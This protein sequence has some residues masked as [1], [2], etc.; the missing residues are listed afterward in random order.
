MLTLPTEELLAG[1]VLTINK[2]LGWTSF[3][4]VKLITAKYKCKA[5]HAG[6]LDPMATGVLVICTGK[7]TKEIES[8]QSQ[9]KDYLATIHI[10]ISRPSFD[11]ETAVHETG[12]TDHINRESVESIL[13]S[14]IGKQEQIAPLFS[15]KKINGVP[16]YELAR[17]GIEKELKA[18]IVEIFNIDLLYLKEVMLTKEQ[19]NGVSIFNFKKSKGDVVNPECLLNI[20]QAKVMELQL[21]IKCGKGTYVRSIARDIALKLN[22]VG[23][24]N[25]LVRT[26]VGNYNLEHS[27]Q[28]D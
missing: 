4:V 15:A 12:P 6:T 9:T 1:T 28:L 21:N 13:K 26:A 25:G 2:P 8:I 10:G 16:V 19:L 24:L 5:G 7:K 20:S 27:I 14:F 17:K 23:T 22:S 11:I 3:D 18:N